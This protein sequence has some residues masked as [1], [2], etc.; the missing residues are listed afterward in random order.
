MAEETKVQKKPQN[1]R[2]WLDSYQDKFMEAIPR[3]TIDVGRFITAASLEIAASDKLQKCDKVSIF[4]SLLESARYGLEVG[5]LLGQAWLIPYNENK[6]T[7]QGWQKVLTCHFQLGYKGLIVLARRSQT[8][9]TITAEIVYENDQ[10]EVELG[11]NRHLTHKIDIRK[12]R[13]APIAY[14]CLVELE[15]GGCQFVVMTKGDAEK[16]RDN[17]SKAHQQKKKGDESTWDTNFDE[18]ALKTCVIKN[19]K[20]CPI[21]IEALEAAGREERHEEMRNVTPTASALPPPPDI[22]AIVNDDDEGGEGTEGDQGAKQERPLEQEDSFLSKG[23]RFTESEVV[24]EQEQAETT[25]KPNSPTAQRAIDAARRAAASS[26]MPQGNTIILGDTS[27]KSFDDIPGVKALREKTSQAAAQEKIAEIASK[28]GGL[29]KGTDFP[30][31][32]PEPTDDQA[33]SGLD[34]F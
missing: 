29:K 21:S 1:M 22:G 20:L 26:Q 16:H 18:M 24:L 9:K 19:L 3:N 34:I 14:Y 33:P 28:T 10:F 4:K 7:P 31:S 6:Q 17:Y 11:Q 27:P 2:E 12:E 13:G 15:N 5:K 32:R 23:L 25:E 8:I 30:A